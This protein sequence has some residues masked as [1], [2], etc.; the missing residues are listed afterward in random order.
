MLRKLI[1]YFIRKSKG[2]N[3]GFG[4][5][6]VNSSF[7]KNNW[8]GKNV[9]LTNSQLGRYT[10]ISDE[11]RVRDCSIGAFCS[12]GRNVKIGLAFH[13][14][15]YISTS[16]FLYRRN[17][18]GINGLSE[19]DLFKLEDYRSTNI[20]NDVWIGDNVIICGGCTINDGVII[21]AGAVVT[22]DLEPFGIY[23]GVPASL[24]KKRNP[25]LET[26]I[27]G[28][29]NWWELSECDISKIISR[30]DD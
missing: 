14:V 3:V 1:N 7:S 16:P 21:G 17:F 19:K 18:L 2:L 23:A 12:I 22:K 4:T 8:L 24:I 11:S 29:I 26:K 15:N 27:N 6:I 9:S 30:Y 10:Y 5:T 20:G 28:S 13:P 25:P